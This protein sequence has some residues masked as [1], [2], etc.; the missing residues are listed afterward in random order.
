MGQREKLLDRARRAPHQLRFVDAIW[1]AEAHGFNH[2]RTR[3]SHIM[4]KSAGYPKLLN[5]QNVDGLAPVY[6]VK[7]L[8]AAIDALANR[9]D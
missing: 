2:V 7:Q 9:S 8:L 1:L 5:L 3:G 6:Q 4:F